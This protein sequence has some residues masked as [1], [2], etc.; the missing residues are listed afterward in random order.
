[1]AKNTTSVDILVRAGTG[2]TPMIGTIPAL[3]DGYTLETLIGRNGRVESRRRTS[4]EVTAI[5]NRTPVVLA[6]IS[7]LLPKYARIDRVTSGLDESGT[8]MIVVTLKPDAQTVGWLE[9]K[10]T[11]TDVISTLAQRLKGVVVKADGTALPQASVTLLSA[12]ALALLDDYADVVAQ[13]DVLA[14]ATTDAESELAYVTRRHPSDVPESTLALVTA[15]NAERA[16]RA[17]INAYTTGNAS[18]V[19]RA[20]ARTT[21]TDGTTTQT[22][23]VPASQ[24]VAQNK[25]SQTL[26]GGLDHGYGINPDGTSKGDVP[27]SQPAKRKYTR[28]ASQP[29]V[30]PQDV[31][32]TASETARYNDLVAVKPASTDGTAK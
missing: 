30:R 20:L 16:N 11:S 31:A 28:K 21:Q 26:I 5:L 32:R 12:L 10:V 1:M 4:T 8:G 24:I 6:Q 22:T 3:G 14:Q 18:V 2:Q 17:L 7:A 25:A 27:A 15:R 13:A 9:S 23:V 19:R 29:N